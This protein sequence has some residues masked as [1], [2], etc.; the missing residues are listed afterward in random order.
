MVI[1][2]YAGV[3]E[4]CPAW[5]VVLATGGSLTTAGTLYFSFQ[6]QNRAGFNIPS[7][8]S[9]VAYSP[10]QKIT[11]TIPE[12]V[13]QPGWDIHYFILSAGATSDPST[14]VQIARVGG[15]QYGAGIEPQSVKTLLPIDIELTRDAHVALTPSTP[16]TNDLPT[17]AD[18]LDGQVRWVTI[19]AKLFEYRADSNLPISVDV[20][21]A[22]I[23]QWVRI[24]GASTYVSDTRAGMGSDRSIVS[25]NPVTTIPTPPYPGDSGFGKVL[26]SWESKY[27]IYNDTPSTLIAGTEFGIELE[28]NN[29]RSPDL[30]SGLFMMRF[31]GYVQ[32]DGTLRTTDGEGREFLTVG[33]FYPWTPKVTTPFVTPDDLQ[34]GEAIALGVKPYFSVAE[35]NNEVPPGTVIGV[36]PVI[37]TQSGDYNPLGKLI[38][39]GVVYAEADR[40]RVVP[41]TGLSYDLL[42][43]M[44]LVGS[45]DFP[46]KPRRTFGGLEPNTAGQKVIINGNGAVFTEEPI[47]TPSASEALRALVGTV[48][49]V[50]T[51]GEWSSYAAI[52][53]GQAATITL[54]YPCDSGGYGTVRNDHPDVIA[55][56]N[57]ALFNPPFIRIYL[58]RQDT[59]EIR[60]FTGYA[61]IANTSQNF[62]LAD[63]NSGNVIS[64][65]PISENDFSIYAPGATTIASTSGGTF[66]SANYRATYAFE[67][68][69]N[70]VTSVSHVSPPCITEFSGN[71]AAIFDSNVY[72][73]SQEDSFI[74]ALIFG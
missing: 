19:E 30:L 18:R 25:I 71:F 17:G 51:A 4:I 67:Y 8:S 7:V 3:G 58:Q 5:D 14:H 44:A 16:T 12:E 54:L 62:T 27:W 23:G 66:P 39:E 24:G 33:A 61:V 37:R 26:P 34:P 48:A 43:G 50:S 31:L 73:E 2:Q 56:N 41:N 32:P 70:Q 69:G 9:A 60:E 68:D 22:D 63:W 55:G 11:I 29:K 64:L 74:N 10:N 59:G 21:A 53:P 46:V 72:I 36:L 45:Y 13:M 65:L 49:G 6:L 52:A 35:L 38:P 1:S 42:S 47:Y 28:Y 20:V 57:K 40:Y 15:Y